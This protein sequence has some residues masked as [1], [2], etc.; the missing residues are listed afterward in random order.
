MAVDFFIGDTG[1][2][3]AAV[4]PSY[5]LQKLDVSMYTQSTGFVNVLRIQISTG[6]IAA[7]SRLIAE[8]I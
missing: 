1:V 7:G 2:Q 6:S 4:R 5:G 8:G 3:A